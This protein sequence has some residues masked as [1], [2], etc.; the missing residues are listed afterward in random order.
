MEDRIIPILILIAA[1]EFT[2][3]MFAYD[4]IDKHKQRAEYW[5][6]IAKEQAAIA[7]PLYVAPIYKKKDGQ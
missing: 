1:L 2:L 7:H 5:R 4:K 6:Q 3:L